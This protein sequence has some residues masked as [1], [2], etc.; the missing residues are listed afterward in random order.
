MIAAAVWSLKSCS[1]LTCAWVQVLSPFTPAHSGQVWGDRNG[2]ILSAGRTSG[3]VA[4]VP[5]LLDCLFIHSG[6]G[7]SSGLIFRRGA[8]ALRQHVQLTGRRSNQD[9]HQGCFE[10]SVLFSNPSALFQEPTQI[11][12]MLKHMPLLQHL[13]PY[14]S[15]KMRPDTCLQNGLDSSSVAKAVS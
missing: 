1:T 9:V 11:T 4:R 2:A 12:R 5:P 3:K 15:E 8:C 7:S 14:L 13:V 6:S 10:L